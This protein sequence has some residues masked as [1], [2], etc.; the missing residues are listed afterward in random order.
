MRPEPVS[1][2]AG[3]VPR[4]SFDA[5][6]QRHNAILREACD[7]G[8]HEHVLDV[9]CGTG[10]TT[11]EAARA[12]SS[13][14]VLGVDTSEAAIARARSLADSE[15]IHNVGFV[16]ADAEVHDFAGRRFDVAISR[17]GTMF[18]RDP[19]AAFTNI[20]RALK[21]GGRLVMLVWQAAELNEWD[22]EI[23]GALAR[24]E[25]AAPSPPDHLDPFSLG[26]AAVLTE[27]LQTAGFTGIGLADVREPVY[28][29]PD[30]GVALEWAR[31]F[32]STRAV[33]QSLDAVAAE[34]AE[35]R[36]QRVIAAHLSDE[37]VWF[38]SRAW[39]V[40]ARIPSGT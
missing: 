22:V 36:L 16:C 27:V 19:V 6:L 30:V 13:G 20:G 39:L 4:H 24:P 26:E 7:I 38:E 31:G 40:S 1:A 37:G 33:V 17:F 8:A 35:A 14:S 10:L 18:F 5:E 15:G 25:A 21:H 3:R 34:R 23:R 28:Y 29:G 2:V 32:A 11:R 9:G 12:A